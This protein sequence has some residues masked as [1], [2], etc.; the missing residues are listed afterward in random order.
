MSLLS[1]FL[2][3]PAADLS[4]S[5]LIFLS[6]ALCFLFYCWLLFS[7]QPSTKR[8]RFFSAKIFRFL[9]FRLDS[10]EWKKMNKKV[11]KSGF[12]IEICCTLAVKNGKQSFSYTQTKKQVRKLKIEIACLWKNCV[13][14]VCVG[15]FIYLCVPYIEANKSHV[16]GGL[17]Y[18]VWITLNR[19]TMDSL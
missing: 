13:V 17:S 7:L 5:L 6:F 19:I 12:T 11:N 18:P 8:N 14:C 15:L 1:S 2:Y 16:A 3:A 9:F 4:L 10:N